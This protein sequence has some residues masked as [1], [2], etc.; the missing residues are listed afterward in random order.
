MSDSIVSMRSGLLGNQASLA[1]D[2]DSFNCKKPKSNAL[3][4]NSNW[5]SCLHTRK[6]GIPTQLDSGFHSLSPSS[7][8]VSTF[9]DLMASFPPTVASF[10]QLEK[11][12]SRDSSLQHP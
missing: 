3:S 8:V 9:L 6:T 1:I 7:C 2:Q 4:T 11:V 10:M 5:L 12:V